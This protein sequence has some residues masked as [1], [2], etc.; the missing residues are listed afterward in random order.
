M[1]K[2]ICPLL[3]PERSDEFTIYDAKRLLG[4]S[5]NDPEVHCFDLPWLCH[6]LAVL[7]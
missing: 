5:Y 6:P 2:A 7:L 1:S 4:R 3:Q